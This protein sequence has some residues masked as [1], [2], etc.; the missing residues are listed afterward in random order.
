MD[1]MRW[2]LYL[3]VAAAGAADAGGGYAAVWLGQYG[4]AW[5]RETTMLGAYAS[6]QSFRP[7]SQEP[8]PEQ[9][10]PICPVSVLLISS[11][12]SI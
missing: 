3:A 7:G 12:H 11:G 2:C 6:R 1:R 8:T 5:G 10:S 9:V 4:V